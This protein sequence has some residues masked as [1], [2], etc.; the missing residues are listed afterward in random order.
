MSN[1]LDQKKQ[2]RLEPKRIRTVKKT[3][4]Q[5][6]FNIEHTKCEKGLI[7]KRDKQQFIIYPYSG[8]WSG[9]GIGQGRGFV[10]LIE[11]L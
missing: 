8:W 7:C 2:T 4:E 5:M 10:K 1:R 6:N 11:K 3:L 9:K